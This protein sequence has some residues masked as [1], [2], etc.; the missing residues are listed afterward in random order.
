MLFM[1]CNA[2]VPSEKDNITSKHQFGL[3]EITFDLGEVQCPT[4]WD[5]QPEKLSILNAGESIEVS[6]YKINGDSVSFSLPV[7]KTT[8]Q[9]QFQK[10]LTLSGV[11]KNQYRKGDYKI[12]FSGELLQK[13]TKDTTTEN[14]KTT[15]DVTMDT[16]ENAYKAIGIFNTQGQK[17]TGTFLTETGDYRFLEG[18]KT[19]KDEFY[20]SCFDGSHL[21]YFS[22]KMNGD[23]I[24]GKFYSGNHWNTSWTGMLD[25]HVSLSNPNELTY[26]KEGETS[27]DFHGINSA[28]DSIFHNSTDFHKVTVI[29]I[30]GTWCP[31]CMDESNYYSNLHKTYRAN[32]DFLGLAFER[33]GEL[34]NRLIDIEHY[35]KSLNVEYPILLSG[36][37]SKSEASQMFSELN[38]ISSF[39]TT[40]FLDKKGMV[41]KIH[42]GFYGPGTGE[43]YSD[44]VKETEAFLDELIKE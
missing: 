11:F 26:L 24:N 20:L 3:Y 43:Y 4:R 18:K 13:E 44:Y 28:G 23:S 30:L 22:A 10:D 27:V 12:A 29:Q 40:I 41:R 17:I 31:N 39:P 5:I 16:G 7:F 1:R 33:P 36:D 9:F 19:S 38:G 6:D 15:Y 32:V 42:T 25:E 8:I 34:S 37:A 35:K 14:L 2:S 21:F